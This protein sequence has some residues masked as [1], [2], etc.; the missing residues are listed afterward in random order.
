M[1][2]G[3]GHAPEGYASNDVY[4]VDLSRMV[5]M[6]ETEFVCVIIVC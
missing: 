5:S 1:L 3:G 4:V 6:V 2:F